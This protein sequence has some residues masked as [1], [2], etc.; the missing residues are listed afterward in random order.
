MVN[1]IKQWLV[2]LICM[3]M[4]VGCGGGGK[5]SNSGQS[6]LSPITTNIN[7]FTVIGTSITTGASVPI[8]A[9]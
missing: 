1:I 4:L 5:D 9:G 7:S 8:N 6:K 3:L 2:N